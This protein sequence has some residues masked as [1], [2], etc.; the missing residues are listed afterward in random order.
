MAPPSP[1][2]LQVC[3]PARPHTLVPMPPPRYRFEFMLLPG[4]TADDV[5]TP[6]R[7]EEFLRPWL[8][9]GTATVERSAVYTFHGLIA[10]QWRSGR[11]FL[12]GDAAHQ[13]PPFLGQGM[14]S[15]IRDAA[16]LAWELER[17]LRHGAADALLDTYQ[18]EREP[19]VRFIVGLAVELGRVICTLDPEVAAGRNAGMLAE[20][21]AGRGTSGEM[22]FP[23][24][25]GGALCGDGGGQQAV[26]PTVA[27]TRLDDLVGPRFAL[28]TRTDAALASDGAQ[29]WQA[30]GAVLLSAEAHPELAPVLDAAEADAVVIR[31]DR[32]LLS[33]AAAV[34][35]PSAGTAALIGS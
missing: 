23:P 10:E 20:R 16:N 5:N 31:P 33:A 4:E 26:Q 32:Y 22:G 27:G 35:M 30:A 15:G 3:D 29:W 13:T 9:A 11:V 17:V 21:E 14:C 2:A 12:A 28:I 6:E 18:T 24:L 1:I 8:A 25:P 19:S 7:V 34:A